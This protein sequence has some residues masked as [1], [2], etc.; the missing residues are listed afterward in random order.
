MVNCGR[1]AC[2]RNGQYL[3]KKACDEN[4]TM[5]QAN[6]HSH[7]FLFD[8][9]LVMMLTFA[10]AYLEN[11]L[12][13]LVTARPEWMATREKMVSGEV[14][15]KVETLEP[16]KQWRG[17]MAIMRGRWA[18]QFLRDTPHDW[19]KRLMKMGVGQYR[20]SLTAEMTIIGVGDMRL[21]IRQKLRR[22][23]I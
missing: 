9:M 6:A 14:V 7:F 2:A 21:F 11:A 12:L 17:F 19:I 16:E 5:I 1:P 13:L 10:E 22:K 20:A 3:R 4:S 23:I 15:S 8:W 18:K